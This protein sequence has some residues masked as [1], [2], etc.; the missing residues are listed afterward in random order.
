MEGFSFNNTA[1]TSQSTAQPKLAGNAIYDVTFDGCEIKDIDG[2]KDPTAKYKN[3]IIKFK[4]EDGVFEHT[5]WEPRPDDFNRRETEFKDK[6]GKINK[7]PQPSNVESMMLLFKHVIDSV[8]PKVAEAIDKKEKSLGAANWDDLRTLIVKILDPMKDKG[9]KVKIK[10]LKN[11][12][13][14]DAVF[15]GFFAGLTKE[16][17]AYVK[18]NFIGP[19]VAFTTYEIQRIQN[20]ANAKPS[21]TKTFGDF[22][23]AASPEGMELDFDVSS[24]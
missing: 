5:V 24:I 10:L 20:E 2:V 16:G 7:I 9:I 17:V 13:S 21:Q 4:N 3:L 18:N 19:K 22:P 1:G 23:Q 11:T 8:N 6:D 15:P 14:G 12:K